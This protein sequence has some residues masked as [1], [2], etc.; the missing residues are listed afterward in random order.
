[1]K[2]LATIEATYSKIDG[3]LEQQ[4]D[5]ATAAGDRTA[6]SHVEQRQRI[7]DQ[8][9]FV[10]C[11]GQ[12]ELE[13]NTRCRNAIRRRWK[14]RQWQTRRGWDLYNPDDDRLS[15]LSFENRTAL[16]LDRK[17]GPGSPWARVMR[18][19]QVRNQIAHGTL[20]AQRIDVSA[21]VADF[22]TI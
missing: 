12:L 4:R 9:Y 5:T 7:N 11:W 15:G 14:S 18:H 22:Y 21:T 17:A 6:A 20:L 13:I 19:Y 1:M 16:I 8:A 10:L 3:A 2:D